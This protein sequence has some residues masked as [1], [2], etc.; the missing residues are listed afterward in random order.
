MAESR[1]SSE[2]PVNVDEALYLRPRKACVIQAIYAKTGKK[3]AHFRAQIHQEREGKRR[4][5]QS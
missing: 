1:D 4:F 5:D 3:T 2:W